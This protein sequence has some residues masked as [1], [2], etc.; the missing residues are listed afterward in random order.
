MGAADNL[1][2]L[3]QRQAGGVGDQAHEEA[4]A[5]NRA[6]TEEAKDDAESG[7]SGTHG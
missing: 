5:P 6:Q 1:A 2:E 7:P 3:E 4:A